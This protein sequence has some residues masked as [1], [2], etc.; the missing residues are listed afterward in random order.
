ME[1]RTLAK[2]FGV[3]I[4]AAWDKKFSEMEIRSQITHL[5]S[6]IITLVIENYKKPQEM[7]KEVKLAFS[8]TPAQIRIH[9]HKAMTQL[10]NAARGSRNFD[11]LGDLTIDGKDENPEVAVPQVEGNEEDAAV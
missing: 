2:T 4:E 3:T 10:F 8:N 7:A 6:R 9:M 11:D 5:E 1:A